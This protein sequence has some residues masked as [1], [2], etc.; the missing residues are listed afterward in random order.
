MWQ[1]MHHTLLNWL[2]LLDALPYDR[3]A[4]SVL[5]FLYLACALSYLRFLR[6]AASQWNDLLT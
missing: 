2:G 5:A 6:R 4:A 1:A 3:H